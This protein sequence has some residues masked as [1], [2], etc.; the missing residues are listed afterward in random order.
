MT[1][2][3]FAGLF[4]RLNRSMP[5]STVARPV[6]VPKAQ[7]CHDY[8][9]ISVPRFS[10]AE[11][12]GGDQPGLRHAPPGVLIGAHQQ[13]IDQILSEFVGTRSIPNFE[14]WIIRIVAAFAAYTSSLPASH[15]HHHSIPGGL[16]SHS[17]DVAHKALMLSSNF[18]VTRESTP[19]A[20]SDD[21]LSWQLVVFISGLLHDLGKVQSM[22]KVSAQTVWLDD[23]QQQPRGGFVPTMP[24]YWH[25]Q[26]CDFDFWVH[27]NHV[28][29]YILD[30]HVSGVEAHQRAIVR[31][32][33]TIVP[34]EIRSFIY[35]SSPDVWR[36][37]EAFLIDPLG[38]S[39][40]K[41]NKVVKDADGLSVGNNMNPR[42]SPGASVLVNQA[43]RRMMEYSQQATWNLPNSPFLRAYVE[44]TSGSGRIE[45]IQA[46]FFVATE[47]NI[48]DFMKY[49]DAA[50]A[51]HLPLYKPQS[52]RGREAV[53]GAL[54]KVGIFVPNVSWISSAQ[55]DETLPSYLSAR[56]A[57]VLFSPHQMGDVTASLKPVEKKLPL[58]PVG[59]VI[60]S[61]ISNGLPT[62]SF[63]GAPT[64]PYPYATPVRFDVDGKVKPEDPSRENDPDQMAGIESFTH[65]ALVKG[66]RVTLS[67]A[68]LEAVTASMDMTSKDKDF[69]KGVKAEIRKCGSEDHTPQ[70]PE[71]FSGRSDADTTLKHG[72]TTSSGTPVLPSAV[73][74]KEQAEGRTEGVPSLP[75][76]ENEVELWVQA[77][78]AQGTDACCL[79]ASI[80]LYMEDLKMARCEDDSLLIDVESFNLQHRLNFKGDLSVRRL[81]Q[82]KLRA[83]PKDGDVLGHHLKEFLVLGPCSTVFQL[84]G[85]AETLVKR[86]RKTVK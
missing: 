48:A 49:F 44:V 3:K 80:F 66:Q 23:A 28:E 31:Y 55:A 76:K 5:P 29:A 11:V 83:W 26:V 58:I 77:W 57:H 73:P 70:E 51:V 24:I 59:S 53:F 18:A 8:H 33:N 71:T 54:E 46:S 62:L 43:M 61:K 16:F 64:Q 19:L 4:R 74:Q 21:Y 35:D 30:H 50:E 81:D 27:A 32:L 68:Q 69:S 37:F 63:W 9:G 72:P 60:S 7:E 52:N 15:G 13:T 40:D 42:T 82:T 45:L 47:P 20:R 78:R 36:L 6:D 10:S 85:D 41:L 39:M 14:R 25:P 75:A 56:L 67:S 38:A 17:L 12:T 65:A 2:L 84:R 34:A 86:L 1:G 22:G 79:T